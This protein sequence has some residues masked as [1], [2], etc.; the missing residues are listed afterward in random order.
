MLLR[1]TAPILLLVATSAMHAQY[2]DPVFQNGCFNWY[3]HS[4]DLAELSW[5]STDCNANDQTDLSATVTAGVPMPMQ[6]VNGNWCGCAI[7]VDLDDDGEFG[8]DEELYHLYGNNEVATYDLELIVPLGTVEGP[9]RMRIISAWGSDGVSE[10]PNGYGPCGAYQYGNHV[11]FI[12][13]VEPASSIEEP[14]PLVVLQSANP[15]NGLLIFQALVPIDR[16]SIRSTDG[17]LVL[18]RSLQG[19]TGNVQLDLSTLAKGCFV[20]EYA[21]GEVVQRHTIV[22]DR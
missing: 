18:D 20:V 1:R 8:T 14:D 2:C 16:V 12:L 13:N 21:S 9:H 11:D 4:V 5:S 15:T 6:V 17:K 3:T 10:G 22:K 7:W 19:G